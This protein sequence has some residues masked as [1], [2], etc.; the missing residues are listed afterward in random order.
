MDDQSDVYYAQVRGIMIDSFQEKSAYLSWLIPTTESPNPREG[1]DAATYI[2]GHDEELSR[3][4]S[5]MQFV[6]HAPS[7]YY[8][9]RTTPF[10]PPTTELDEELKH[11]YTWK[12]EP[13]LQRARSTTSW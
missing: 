12:R 8:L 1:F 5:C 9:D 7:N 6:M 2:L 11:E 3:K 10:P 13:R 4:L